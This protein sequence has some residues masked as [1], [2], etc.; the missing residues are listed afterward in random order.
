MFTAK[1]FDLDRRSADFEIMK[2]PA[3]PV[4]PMSPDCLLG[5]RFAEARNARS[6]AELVEQARALGFSKSDIEALRRLYGARSL[7]GDLGSAEARDSA[8]P[9]ADG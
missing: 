2:K 8:K 3:K 1:C 6:T 4:D 5:T 7:S 9:P